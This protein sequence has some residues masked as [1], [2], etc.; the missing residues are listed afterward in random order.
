[1][2]R[3]RVALAAVGIGLGFCANPAVAQNLSTAGGLAEACIFRDEGDRNFCHGLLFG[4]VQTAAIYRDMRRRG[5]ERVLPPQALVVCPPS[6]VDLDDLRE[7]YV[8]WARSHNVARMTLGQAA[9]NALADMYP[10]RGRDDSIF[11]RRDSPFGGFGGDSFIPRV[12]D[13]R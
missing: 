3:G 6:R 2:V 13:S 1:M 12:G 9:F 10:C 4:V 7:G 8:R 11:D 5:G